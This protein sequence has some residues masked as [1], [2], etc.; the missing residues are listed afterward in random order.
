MSEIFFVFFVAANCIITSYS[1]RQLEKVKL[2]EQ[3][4]NLQIDLCII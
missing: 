2:L 3:S 4:S 1:S